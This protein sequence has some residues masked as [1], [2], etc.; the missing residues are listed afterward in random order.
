MKLL[1]AGPSPFVRKVLVLLHET[2]Q[3]ADIQL[4]QV[5]ASPLDPD[6]ALTA[7]NPTGK[8]PALI[9]DDGP[10]I[11]DSRVIC[12]YLDARVHAGLY[13]ES[14]IWETLTLEATADAM[15]EAAVL[16]VY[17][18]RFKTEKQQSKDWIEG[19][20]A[21][22]NRAVSILNTRWTSHLSGPLDVAHIAV[23]CALGYLDFR[24]DDRGWRHGND[25]LKDWY[26]T[27]SQRDSMM[28]TTPK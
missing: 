9:R 7:I 21:K 12:R 10:A 5:V 20:W 19:Q 26:Q 11:Y 8:I 28:K 27:F 25:A 13:P 16:M 15:M 4:Q 6:P 2:G 24:H 17:E 18:A 23:G 3:T 14:R 1:Y 22:V